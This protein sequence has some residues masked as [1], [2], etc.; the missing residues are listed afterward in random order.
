[1]PPKSALPTSYYFIFGVYEPFLTIAG[2]LGTWAN[3]KAAHDS[4]APWPGGEPPDELPRACFVSIIQLAH[5]CAL[6][7]LLNVSLLSACRSLDRYP[8]LQE[9]IV[10]ALLFPLLLGDVVHMY[11]TLWALGEKRWVF[12]GWPP[13]LWAT[14]LTGLSLLIP[15]LAWHMGICRYVDKRDRE[16]H[17]PAWVDRKGS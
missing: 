2:F 14:I 5:V 10:F 16:F 3:P 17:G 8:A 11:V 7:G 9:K 1:M 6:M 12:S 15:R 13:V 4:Q